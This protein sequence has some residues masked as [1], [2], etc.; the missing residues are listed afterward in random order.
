MLRVKTRNEGGAVWGGCI[1]AA[2]RYVVT[3][4]YVS[5]VTVRLGQV[6]SAI[7]APLPPLVSTWSPPLVRDRRPSTALNPYQGFGKHLGLAGRATWLP[8]WR[9]VKPY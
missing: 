6:T 2:L 4:R 3:L 7:Y 1:R 9:E 5:Y 8:A